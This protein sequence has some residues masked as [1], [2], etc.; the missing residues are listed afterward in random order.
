MGE[1]GNQVAPGAVMPHQM[2][3]SG[4][5]SNNIIFNINGNTHIN[6]FHHHLGSQ[7]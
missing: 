7:Y 6:N 1:V 5:P 4:L 2:A 3:E